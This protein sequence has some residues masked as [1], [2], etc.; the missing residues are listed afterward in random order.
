MINIYIRIKSLRIVLF[1][2]KH[3][4][5]MGTS[6]FLYSWCTNLKN[7]TLLDNATFKLRSY[8]SIL[9]MTNLVQVKSQDYNLAVAIL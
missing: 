4:V 3:L 2:R 8:W 9:F 5:S 1:C 6:V 7:S